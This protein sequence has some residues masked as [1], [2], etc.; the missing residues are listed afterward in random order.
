LGGPQSRSG[1]RGED[2]IL[3]PTGTLQSFSLREGL[4]YC[5]IHNWRRYG[6]E[7]DDWRLLKTAH[8]HLPP[9]DD[10]IPSRSKAGITHNS[11]IHYFPSQYVKFEI[12]RKTFSETPK[13]DSTSCLDNH[14][15]RNHA[16]FNLLHRISSTEE[17]SC[18]LFILKTFL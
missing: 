12:K 1:R 8:R 17:Q 13:T 10:E 5:R 18:P 3:D 2:K 4:A 14:S 16:P 6:K 7:E 15:F 11:Q 9:Q